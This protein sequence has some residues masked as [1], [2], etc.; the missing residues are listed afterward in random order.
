MIEELS[1]VS[2][3]RRWSGLPRLLQSRL[4]RL[5]LLRLRLLRHESRGHRRGRSEEPGGPAEERAA[6]DPLR[7]V[8]HT[9][10]T[11]G[12]LSGAGATRAVLGA[13]GHIVISPPSTSTP[14]PNQTHHT[15]GLMLNRYTACSV[16]F[17]A[18]AKTI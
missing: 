15:S 3:S 12:G 14:P 4:L 17:T 10:S 8:A 1:G 11:T 2:L 9:G 7:S 6:A 18:P 13:P 5:R 16:P